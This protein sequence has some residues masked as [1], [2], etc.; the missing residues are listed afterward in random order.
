MP[1]HFFQILKYTFDCTPKVCLIKGYLELFVIVFGTFAALATFVMSFYF[2]RTGYGIGRAVALGK[3]A[4]G[5]NMIIILIF[6]TTYFCD[7]FARMHAITAA[8]LRI[9]AVAATIFSTVHL[10]IQTKRVIDSENDAE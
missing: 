4:E 1:P 7:W 10:A 8:C 5:L 9:A 3:L 6:A 2:S